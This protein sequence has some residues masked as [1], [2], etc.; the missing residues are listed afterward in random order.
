MM[1]LFLV[2]F[3]LISSLWPA[4]ALAAD[5][6]FG[7]ANYLPILDETVRDGDIVSS[8]LQGFIL[9]KM[10]YDPMLVGVVTEKAAIS[11]NT[12]GE[13]KK[14]PVVSAGN[15][16]VNVSTIGGPIKKG[17]PVTSSEI[18]GVAM[19]A[20]RSGFILGTA[21]ADYEA[22]SPQEIGKLEVALNFH[23]FSVQRNVKSGLMDI[24]KLSSL[25]TYEEPRTVFKYF[26]AAL[27][28]LLSFV[29]GFISFGR[30]AA[31]GVDALGRNP[32][33]SR[34]IQ[35]GIVINVLITVAIVG[36][37][38]GVAVFILNM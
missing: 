9:S 22:A 13:A 34:M 27:I 1:N 36:A 6:S 24:I 14:Y 30:V 4:K 38:M 31:K 20:S 37:G 11:F 7:V 29:L 16:L 25:A 18:P 10:T 15:V 23:Y 17:D 5:I 21:L 28:V 2:I 32:L 26:V 35:L 3:I 8:S 12:T 19:K 33:A